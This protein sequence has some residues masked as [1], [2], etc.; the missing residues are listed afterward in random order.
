MC[1]LPPLLTQSHP[2]ETQQETSFSTGSPG[3]LSCFNIPLNTVDSIPSY[4]HQTGNILFHMFSQ[5]SSLCFS[6]PL[7]P[8]KAYQQS[9]E[10]LLAPILTCR[11]SWSPDVKIVPLRL[12]HVFPHMRSSCTLSECTLGFVITSVL[13]RG[14]TVFVPGY[15]CI[16]VLP[17]RLYG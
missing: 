7:N 15:Q 4:R 9:S 10:S 11:R 14:V 1:S 13:R 5:L 17:A 12:L 6:I 16:F 3:S 8:T 2:V